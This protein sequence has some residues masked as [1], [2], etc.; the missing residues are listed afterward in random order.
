MVPN[1]AKRLIYLFPISRTAYSCERK[2][3]ATKMIFSERFQDFT[4]TYIH[5]EFKSSIFNLIQNARRKVLFSSKAM[6]LSHWSFAVFCLKRV[7]TH[8]FVGL[9]KNL[10]YPKILV[11][12]DKDPEI[13]LKFF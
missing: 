5:K 6:F 4:N 11:K 8:F 12:I 9:L 13:L 3:P 7:L 10:K 2:T 1:R